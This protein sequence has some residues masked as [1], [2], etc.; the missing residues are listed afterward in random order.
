MTKSLSI[1]ALLLLSGCGYDY[2]TREC[3][4]ALA[5]LN[6]YAS[7]VT[8]KR[9]TDDVYLNREFTGKYFTAVGRVTA[10]RCSDE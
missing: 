5:D 6:S 1:C 4:L 9:C 2:K 7:C 10:F 8:D 3:Y